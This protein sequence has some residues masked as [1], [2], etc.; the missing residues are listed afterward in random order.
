[1]IRDLAIVVP[2]FNG[3]TFLRRSLPSLTAQAPDAEV[4]VVD[5]G[6]TDD[7]ARVARELGATVIALRE[8]AGP[9]RARNAGV[10]RLEAEVVLFLDADCVPH[11]DVVAR[12]RAA[13][14]HDRD[15][16][17]LTGSYDD[18]PPEPGF[19]SQYMN[20]RHHHFHQ[21]ARRENATFWAGC[22]AVRRKAFVAVGGFDEQ[23]YPRPQIEDI[24][25]GLRLRRVG[26]TR[27][28]PDLQVTHLK[29]W[30][31]R[32][33]IETDIRQ[34]A[35]PWAR[36]ILE[37]GS[38]PDDLNLTWSQRAAALLSPLLLASLLLSPWAVLTGRWA[39]LAI[40]GGLTLASGVLTFDLLR[41]F[42]RVRGPW[43]A[44]RAWL[45]QQVHLFYGSATLG[46]CTL[47]HLARTTRRRLVGSGSRSRQI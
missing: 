30:T 28:D 26:Q 37:S 22:G 42:T 45:F 39:A 43:F 13:F 9:A 24:E 27:L 35:I 41:F 3:A 6:S 2:V 36:L 46:L 23:R 18:A 8:R 10:S 1:M 16:V 47:L 32:S 40:A 29:R 44:A 14:R 12:V 34:R 11:P 7:S 19:F 5:A 25:L 17:S 31:L 33:V 15:L 4:A 21:R 38:L 20:L